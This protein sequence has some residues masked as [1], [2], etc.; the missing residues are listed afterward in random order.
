[1]K[2]IP[3]TLIIENVVNDEV[4]YATLFYG[5]IYSGRFFG[6]NSS[7][8]KKLNTKSQ[9]IEISEINLTKEKVLNHK[10]L[11]SD[12]SY[13]YIYKTELEWDDNIQIVDDAP[14]RN[15]MPQ[16]IKEMEKVYTKMQK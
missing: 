16:I 1:M 12:D 15:T 11:P 9:H 13:I 2:S 14:S 8:A 6:K 3:A 7:F 5:V 10:A 4:V